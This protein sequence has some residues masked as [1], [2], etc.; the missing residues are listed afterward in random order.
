MPSFELVLSSSELYDQDKDVEML[1]SKEETPVEQADFMYCRSDQ[2]V[3]ITIHGI[4][5]T[6][7]LHPN[8][9]VNPCFSL[10]AQQRAPMGS[11][12]VELT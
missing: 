7:N 5:V 1:F 11:V 2:T 12:H 6:R 8:V 4:S 3:T 10:I 9:A